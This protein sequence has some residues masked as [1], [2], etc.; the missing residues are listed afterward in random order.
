M[1]DLF[2]FCF[3][4][5]FLPHTTKSLAPFI[6]LL[7][8]PAFLSCSNSFSFTALCC[9]LAAQVRPCNS[10]E[11]HWC[12]LLPAVSDT[13]SSRGKQW[14]L[15]K[16][17]KQQCTRKTCSNDPHFNAVGYLFF[18]SLWKHLCRNSFCALI[19]PYLQIYSRDFFFLPWFKNTRQ[20]EQRDALLWLEA[21]ASAERSLCGR[22]RMIRH[23]VQAGNTQI[24]NLNAIKHKH[25]WT[26]K[27]LIV[28][29]VNNAQNYPHYAQNTNE[30][31]L[32]PL[33]DT[34]H[35]QN[36]TFNS[37]GLSHPVFIKYSLHKE[38]VRS[39]ADCFTLT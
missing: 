18:L 13:L 24:S 33:P 10:A 28:L 15:Y 30:A 38:E 27:R 9:H 36:Y 34:A 17:H 26:P 8:T 25:V 39:P 3:F 22:R 29:N 12:N 37:S 1:I 31:P 16:N 35:V 19:F 11:D 5:F 4:S 14:M 6:P 23:S 7:L 20:C 32:A 2:W 21:A